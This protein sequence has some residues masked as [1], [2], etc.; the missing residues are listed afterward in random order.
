MLMATF[1]AVP[2]ADKG[3]RW[4]AGQEIRTRSQTTTGDEM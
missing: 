2:Q 3:P 1:I 4:G